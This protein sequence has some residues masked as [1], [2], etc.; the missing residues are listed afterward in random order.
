MRPSRHHGPGL[1]SRAVIFVIYLAG[2]MNGS[3][4]PKG[5]NLQLLQA[6]TGCFASAART[7]PSSPEAGAAPGA[8]LRMPFR[9]TTRAVVTQTP[10]AMATR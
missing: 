5:A 8:G 9:T 4:T 6:A 3:H 10:A 1:R 7:A 2:G